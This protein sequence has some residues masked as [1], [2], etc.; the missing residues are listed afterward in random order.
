MQY[1]SAC[2]IDGTTDRG[3]ACQSLPPQQRMV[4]RDRLGGPILSPLDLHP[5]R[6]SAQNHTK[7]LVTF[8]KR[9]A[10]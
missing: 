9:G 7:N 2:P 8:T 4:D 10:V 5:M 1:T 3:T 6:R